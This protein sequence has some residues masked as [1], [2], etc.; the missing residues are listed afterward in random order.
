MSNT[1]VRK[2]KKTLVRTWGT[3]FER[4][5]M[6]KETIPLLG[7]KNIKMLIIFS[8]ASFG[9]FV[10]VCLMTWLTL[11][12]S[13]RFWCLS[14]SSYASILASTSI[15]TTCVKLCE[16]KLSESNLTHKI[17]WVK[18]STIHCTV[19]T[20]VSSCCCFFPLACTSKD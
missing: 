10:S 6:Q 14:C 9:W 4:N 15:H 8:I 1:R 2:K 16:S 7:Y 5:Q 17:L 19:L 11:I 12:L 13:R 20:A 18:S 3:N